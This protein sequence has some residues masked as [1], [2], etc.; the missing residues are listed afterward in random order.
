MTHSDFTL[1]AYRSLLEELQQ[2]GYRGVGYDTVASDQPDLIL[3]HDIDFWPEAALPV[4][5]VERDLGLQADYFFLVTCPLYNPAAPSVRAV[6]AQLI[7]MGHRIGLH[8]DAALYPDD[9]DS[10]NL[11][12]AR[13]AALLEDCCGKPVEMVSFHRP[14]PSLHGS[15]APIAGRPHAYQP[16]YFREIGYCSDSRG[17]WRFGPPLTQD[18]VA[19]GRALQLLTHPIWWAT[20]CGGDRE[21]ALQQF[22]AAKGH[23]VQAALEATITGY[24]S[25]TQSITDMDSGSK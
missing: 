20:N 23:D 3:R 8:F 16:R 21:A 12:A 19:N 5:A 11:A 24:S 13:E 4:A 9:P 18:A 1:T 2:R 17:I 6:F 7:G 14:S 15:A 10:L 22:A 25:E